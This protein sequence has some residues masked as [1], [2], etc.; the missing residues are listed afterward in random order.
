MV[1]EKESMQF[2]SGYQPHGGKQTVVS[3]QQGR[4]EFVPLDETSLIV[5]VHDS[6]YA[7]MTG[8]EVSQA[9]GVRLQAWARVEAVVRRGRA[10]WAGAAVR[11]DPV[12]PDWQPR[13]VIRVFSYGISGT[14]DIH[15][16]VVFDRV[17]PRGAWVAKSLIQHIGSGMTEYSEQSA[18]V[19]LAP[20]ET[21]KVELGGSGLAVI[22]RFSVAGEPPARHQWSLNEAVM[23]STAG[24]PHDARKHY[25]CLIDTDGSFRAEDIAPGR[26]ELSVNLTAVPDPNTCGHGARIGR[27]V[28][29]IEVKGDSPTVDLGVI[30]GSWFKR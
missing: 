29:V 26:Y 8:D 12:D 7:E 30:D 22:G 17:V 9:G 15:G 1:T 6:G 24:G 19:A 16:R 10:L 3:D 4:F 13:Q 25:E 14:T 28:R 11:V 5:A 2:A 23:I 20:G 27:I 18:K 21:A